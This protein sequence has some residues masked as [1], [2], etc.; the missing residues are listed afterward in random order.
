MTDPDL[1]EPAATAA[2][3]PDVPPARTVRRNRRTVGSV[4]RTGVQG[5]GE[6]LITCGLV[7]LLLAA[8]QVWGR[9]MEINAAQDTLDHGL[10]ENW[11]DSKGSA[12]TTSPLPGSAL[13][14]L[15]IPKLHKHWVVVEGV[16]QK[17]LRNA[18]GH[19][20]K[21]AP[22]GKVGNFSVAGH[23]TKAIFWDLDKM[24]AGDPIIVESRTHWY[25]YQVTQVRIVA[26]SASEVVAPVPGRRG[27]KPTASWLTLTT[28]NPKFDNYERLIVH[29]KLTRTQVKTAGQPVELA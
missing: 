13:A 17:A 10:D 11:N 12:D 2:T 7:V 24:R 22:L 19:Y 4:M 14:R 3:T 27:M 1:D 21:T 16:S 29:A 9:T 26:P 5:F 8:Y 20:P 25:V 6:L 28:C 23:R 18:P 15:H